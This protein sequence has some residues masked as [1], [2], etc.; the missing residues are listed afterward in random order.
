MTLQSSVRFIYGYSINKLKTLYKKWLYYIL[1]F[2]DIYLHRTMTLHILRRRWWPIVSP[3]SGVFLYIQKGCIP[4]AVHTLLLAWTYPQRCIL[5]HV[6]RLVTQGTSGLH[7]TYHWGI[8]LL[9]IYMLL[10]V[11]HMYVIFFMMM[12]FSSHELRLCHLESMI[13]LCIW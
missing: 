12:S 3:P 5:D 13:N 11:R 1:F 10:R 9:A 4:L 8:N 7:A 2:K 6:V